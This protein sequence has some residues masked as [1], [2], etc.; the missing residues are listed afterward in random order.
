M[1][2]FFKDTIH[3]YFRIQVTNFES[4]NGTIFILETNNYIREKIGR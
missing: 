4:E 1:I 2:F 3:F